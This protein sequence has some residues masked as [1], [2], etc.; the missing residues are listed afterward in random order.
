ME[1]NELSSEDREKLVEVIHG[2]DQHDLAESSGWK[3][4]AQLS[5]ET[6]LE[7]I[8]VFEDEIIKEDGRYVVPVNVYVTLNYHDSEGDET[9]HD[10][11]PGSVVV[12]V[13][14]DGRPVIRDMSV[15]TSS[16]FE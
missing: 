15:D 1:P 2:R 9:F 4:L 6:E 8:E 10:A 7:D 3:E 11:F 13:D 5:S 12:E 16:F 14:E